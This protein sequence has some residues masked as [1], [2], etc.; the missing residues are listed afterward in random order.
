MLPG[1]NNNIVTLTGE[2]QC[3]MKQLLLAFFF[4]VMTLLSHFLFIY[5]ANI[6][7][8]LHFAPVL[9]RGTKRHAAKQLDA[10]TSGVNRAATA[11]AQH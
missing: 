1:T 6:C 11:V 7:H 8:V 5:R 2:A 9:P 10:Q 4:I 3:L